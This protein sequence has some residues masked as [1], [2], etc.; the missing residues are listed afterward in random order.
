[1]GIEP[2]QSAWKAEGLPLT[3]IPIYLGISVSKDT[4]FYFCQ[5]DNLF[6]TIEAKFRKI[7][8]LTFR[9]SLLWYKNEIP[10]TFILHIYYIIFFIKNQIIF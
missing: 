6:K 2:T 10:S 5:D 9:I 8:L 4:Y 7:F 1:M 3:Y